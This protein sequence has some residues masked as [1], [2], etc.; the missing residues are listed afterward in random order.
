MT[1]TR[2]VGLA[3]V[4]A[5]LLAGTIDDRLPPRA[6]REAGGHTLVAGDFHVHSFFGDGGLAPWELGREARRRGLDVIAVTNHNQLLGAWIA[7]ATHTRPGD[8]I[9]LIGQ[10]VTNGGYHLAAAGLSR[11][12]DWREPARLAI[13]AVQE[14]GGVAIAAHPV[15]S[16][17]RARDDETL[18]LL[19]ATEAA[20]PLSLVSP[21][22]G[23]ELLDFHR[24]TARV[25]S[26]VAPIGSSDFHFGG[27]LGECRT[28]LFVKEVSRQGVIEAIREG[29]T[30]AR[31]GE[32]RL[33]GAPSLVALVRTAYGAQPLPPAAS[34]L[35][36]LAVWL[37]LAGL[38]VVLLFR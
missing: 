9:V 7:A 23:E 17:W 27:M 34:Q 12:V 22:E 24:A 35:S 1:R 16:S 36:R 4:A 10:E 28:F 25:N 37:T 38:A 2:R 30:V 21:A 18:R 13:R 19:D 32:G 31:D 11:R 3:L 5:G 33:F 6:V 14:Q 26:G 29:R 15:N 8:P 20:H